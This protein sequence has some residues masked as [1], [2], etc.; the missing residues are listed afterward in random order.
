TDNVVVVTPTGAG[1]VTHIVYGATF[2]Y[3]ANPSRPVR[4]VVRDKD[5]GKPVAGVSV[6]GWAKGGSDCK[7]VTDREGRYEVLGLA[8]SPPYTLTVNPTAGPPFRHK[9][10]FLDP[11]GLDPLTADIVLVQGLTV[12][13][14][15]TDKAT[16]Q[17]VAGARVDYY[18]F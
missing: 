11:P 1:P 16:G 15:V 2:D 3:V 14:K 10:E 4:G 5:T 18:P 17:P 8:K 12:R 6:E 9:A 13:G 7:A